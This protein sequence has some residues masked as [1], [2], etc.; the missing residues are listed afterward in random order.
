ML[1]FSKEGISGRERKDCLKISG[2][3]NLLHRSSQT[4][5]V[6]SR[7]LRLGVGQYPQLPIDTRPILAHNVATKLPTLVGPVAD[8]STPDPPV[9]FGVVG[10]GQAFARQGPQQS[11]VVNHS[12]ARVAAGVH[13]PLPSILK[14]FL[15]REPLLDVKARILV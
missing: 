14:R 6:G 10:V 7:P 11:V 5:C 1:N 8:K 13:Q 4:L 15:Q 12:V 3:C 2:S 9:S